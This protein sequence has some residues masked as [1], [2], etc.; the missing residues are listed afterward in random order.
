MKVFLSWS[1][2]RSLA[3]ATEFSTWL[4]KII[5]DCRNIYI[6]TETNKGDAWFTSIT[7]A[8]ESSDI[9]VLI[10]TP[11][12]QDAPWLNFEAG[13]LLTNFDKRRLIPVLVG[14][15]KTDYGGP[16]KSLQLTE[17][18]DKVDMRRLLDTIN[19]MTA[20][21]LEKG[22]LDEEHELKWHSFVEG[23]QRRLDTATE[24]QPSS[25]TSTETSRTADEKIDELL[26]LVRDH[27]RTMTGLTETTRGILERESQREREPQRFESNSRAS[28]VRIARERQLAADRSLAEQIFMQTGK[29]VSTS[30]D[31]GR[32]LLVF[33]SGDHDQLGVKVED[34]EAESMGAVAYVANGQV[35]RVRAEA[36][37][38]SP[39]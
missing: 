38:V 3:I 35:Y 1:G 22:F 8:L 33:S 4:P 37:T 39:F 29:T 11:E 19:E 6:S 12:N 9:G 7:E 21:P 16:M 34:A 17:F 25:S 31:T 5:Q 20:D 36:V 2:P 14:F 18:D 28:R 26:E 30:V 24:I 23:A 32:A 13:A 10:L 27:Q 15:K